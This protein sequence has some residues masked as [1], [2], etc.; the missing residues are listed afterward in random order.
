MD[1]VA[2]NYLRHALVKFD[3]KPRPFDM[4]WHGFC[5]DPDRVT[6]PT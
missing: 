2:T 3:T 5:R 1:K 6:Y 4:P